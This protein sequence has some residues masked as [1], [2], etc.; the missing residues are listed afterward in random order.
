MR[1]QHGSFNGGLPATLLTLPWV[2]LAKTGAV[3]F[4]GPA[5]QFL[6]LQKYSSLSFS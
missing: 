1:L 3:S 4:N 6:M 2:Q 5:H